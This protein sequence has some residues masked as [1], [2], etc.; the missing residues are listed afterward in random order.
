MSGDN[1]LNNHE[2]QAVRKL[3]MLDVSEAAEYVGNV[4]PRSWQ[5]WEA[6][7]VP[8]PDD[9]EMEMYGLLQIQDKVVDRLL[10]DGK[11]GSHVKYYHSYQEWLDNIPV[12]NAITRSIYDD[13][14]GSDENN[15]NKMSWKIWQSAVSYVFS[16]ADIRL[17]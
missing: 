15:D 9:V 3:L 14:L 1:R 11:D 17:V 8:I 13:I 5:Y 12:Q 4:S 10:S 6:G 16:I 2:L 7:K